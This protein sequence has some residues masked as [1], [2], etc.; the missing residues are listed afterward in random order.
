M[1]ADFALA[2][3]SISTEDDPPP[4]LIKFGARH[5]FYVLRIAPTAFFAPLL[6]K[7]GTPPLYAFR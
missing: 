2:S 3:F 6:V 5:Y 4:D 1:S 7:H